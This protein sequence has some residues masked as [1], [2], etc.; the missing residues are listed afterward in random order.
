MTA[1][2]QPHTS[3]TAADNKEPALKIHPAADIFPMLDQDEL[4]DL[5]ESIKT[6]GQHEPIVLDPD[7]V[8]LDGRNRLAA[9]KIA[10]VEP[11]FTTYTGTDHMRLIMSGNLVRRHISK[12]QQAMITAMACS[13][14]E[15]SLRDQAKHHGLSLTCL[16]NAATVLTHAPH[17]AEQ[18]RVGTLGLDAAYTAAREQ[19]DRTVALKAQF[20]RLREHAPDLAAQVTEGLLTFDDATA[21]LDERMETERLRQYVIDADTLRLAD[22]DT[23]PP[24]AQLVER[25]DITWGQAH[26][27]AEEFLTHRQ[28]AI[29]RAQNTLQ[30]IADNWTAVQDL[31]ARPDTQLIQDILGGLAPEVRALAQR[32]I[33]RD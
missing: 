6:E 7:G 29:G 32:L 4:L 13:A 17:L 16:S 26:Q 11:R 18:V 12:G 28:E 30:L 2:Q 20:D 1:I 33:T 27:R 31:A 5:A 14:S 21:A 15:H 10:G 22:G 23:T 3:T 24:L 8:L 25:G 9:C 19:R